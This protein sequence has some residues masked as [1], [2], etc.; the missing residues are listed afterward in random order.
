MD[1]ITQ[2]A[3]DYFQAPKGTFWQW[4]DE[5]KVIEWKD[6]KNGNY[7]IC[8]R[9]ELMEILKEVSGDGIPTLNTVL[10]LFLT[11]HNHF[12]NKFKVQEK[13][14]E[15]IDFIDGSWDLSAVECSELNELAERVNEGC[16]IVSNLDES[17][18]VGKN[19]IHLFKEL[20]GNIKVKIPQS[21][22]EEIIQI[23]DSGILDGSIFKVKG[24][25]G[26]RKLK[27]VLRSV[28]QAIAPFK[29]T[30][31]LALKLKTGLREIPEILEIEVPNE[32]ETG[33]LLEQLSDDNRTKGIANLTTRLIAG[34]NI[35]M[36]TAGVSNQAF[37][38]ISDITN[39]GEFDK[40]LLSELANDNE[41]LTAR[42]VNNE[43]LYYQHE[44]PPANENLERNIYLDTT[45]KMWG[46]PK[47]FALS[48]AL[49]CNINN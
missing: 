45:L 4:S 2:L 19:K 20:F 7:T 49:A 24:V 12:S 16:N 11:T 1:K 41:T 3:I 17:F 44:A 43:A 37:G 26:E 9:S 30:A 6:E 32:D 27:L 35:P 18:R 15:I 47:V 8:Y 40:L 22:A 13:I 14:T 28:N 42:L 48:A 31:E 25:I 38:G 36:H 5:G 46:L 10:L 23:F 21:E 29:N 39:R 34:L 33:D